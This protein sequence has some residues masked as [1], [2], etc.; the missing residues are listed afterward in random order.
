MLND[1]AWMFNLEDEHMVF[2]IEDEYMLP[3]WYPSVKNYLNLPNQEFLKNP[4]SY[5]MQ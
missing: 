2:N 1:K 5:Y 4:K 3:I